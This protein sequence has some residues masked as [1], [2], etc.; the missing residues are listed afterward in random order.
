MEVEENTA[1]QVKDAIL[2]KHTP[3]HSLLVTNS[4]PLETAV[5]RNSPIV[6]PQPFQIVNT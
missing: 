3:D 2:P 4:P 1:K 6:F 5:G